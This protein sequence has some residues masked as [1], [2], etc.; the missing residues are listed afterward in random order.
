VHESSSKSLIVVS[1]G[2][3]QS[4]ILRDFSPLP[5]PFALLFVYLWVKII[6][7]DVQDNV[8]QRDSI[9]IIP[10]PDE[11]RKIVYSYCFGRVHED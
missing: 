7:L 2:S 1:D 4:R 5:L 11:E 8:G 3:L 10:V 9:H 6:L